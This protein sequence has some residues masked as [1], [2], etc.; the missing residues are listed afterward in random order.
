MLFTGIAPSP[1][2]LLLSFLPVGCDQNWI[3][4]FCSGSSSTLLAL[5]QLA[6]QLCPDRPYLH[7]FLALPHPSSRLVCLLVRFLTFETGPQHPWSVGLVVTA[8]DKF[9]ASTAAFSPSSISHHSFAL[10]SCKLN[11]LRFSQRFQARWR[12]SQVISV[13]TL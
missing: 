2:N 4:S 12:M 8:L 1:N 11:K 7:L 9:M 10:L 6:R 13:P 3:F 5:W